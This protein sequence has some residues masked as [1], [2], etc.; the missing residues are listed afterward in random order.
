[1]LKND[2]IWSNIRQKMDKIGHCTL[3]LHITLVVFARKNLKLLEILFLSVSKLVFLAC[4]CRDILNYVDLSNC[5]FPRE[6][7]ALVFG[8]PTCFL[9]NISRPIF[10][11]E[12]T[13]PKTL[14]S[15]IWH[16]FLSISTRRNQVQIQLELNFLQFRPSIFHLRQWNA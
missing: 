3:K 5:N 1:M 10:V 2:Q 15:N 16:N 12:T 6:R 14:E 13:K 7:S 11:S 9:A 8:P 4:K